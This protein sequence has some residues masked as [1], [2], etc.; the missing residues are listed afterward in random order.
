MPCAEARITNPVAMTRFERSRKLFRDR[1]RAKVRPG[2]VL[3]PTADCGR[4][5]HP[6]ALQMAT[7]NDSQR[8]WNLLGVF[9]RLLPRV[10]TL[11]GASKPN[12]CGPGSA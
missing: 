1:L 7:L 9:Q 4:V 10:R 8:R 6:L 5:R 12:T 2:R 3:G 11:T